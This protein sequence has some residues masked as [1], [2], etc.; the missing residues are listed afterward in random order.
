M[1]ADLDLLLTAV[2]CAADDFLPESGRN[3]RRRVTDAEV[4]TLCVAQQLLN[5]SS[6]REFLALARRRLGHLFPWLPQQ[7]GN[8]KRRRRLMD[9][10]E[11]L[12]AMFASDSPGY[13]DPVVLVD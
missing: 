11:W 9:A 4:V 8:H 1:L 6:D 3:A 2:F 12:C 5:I 10:I 13:H 7:P